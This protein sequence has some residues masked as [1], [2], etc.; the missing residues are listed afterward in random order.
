MG[1]KFTSHV[2]SHRDDGAPG[3][4][5][6]IYVIEKDGEHYS[7]S[8]SHAPGPGYETLGDPYTQAS[9]AEAGQAEADR[10]NAL[11]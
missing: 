8:S 6:W 3:G 7:E 9:A 2:R 11:E 1:V 4:T 5:A 10:L